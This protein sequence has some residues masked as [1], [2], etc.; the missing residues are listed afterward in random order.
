MRRWRTLVCLSTLPGR[1]QAGQSAEARQ[2]GRMTSEDAAALV[3]RR[4]AG[5]PETLR[6][7]RA[8]W[9]AEAVDYYAEHGAFLGDTDLTWGPE[10]LRESEAH[11]LGDL[12]GKR[13][14][15]IGC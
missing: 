3:T 14:L 12:A 2:T 1:S 7:N 15:E 11:L 5:P 8:W 6:A 13:V 9:D 4:D 10:G